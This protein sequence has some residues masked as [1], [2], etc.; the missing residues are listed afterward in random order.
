MNAYSTDFLSTFSSNYVVSDDK[1][2]SAS[3]RIILT[4]DKEIHTVS[5]HTSDTVK[6]IIYSVDEGE[7]R[8]FSATPGKK[9]FDT[10]Y[11]LGDESL[12]NEMKSGKRLYVALDL[13]DGAKNYYF[14]RVFS[15]ENMK[16]TCE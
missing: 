14:Y 6:T 1:D 11:I 15:L 9:Y 12:Y 3:E 10:G 5:I 7:P 13:N 2:I 8:T 16:A 4:I